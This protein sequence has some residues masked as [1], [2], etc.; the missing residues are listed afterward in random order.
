[1]QCCN[2]G[3]KAAISGVKNGYFYFICAHKFVAVAQ[4][5]VCVFHFHFCHHDC[6]SCRRRGC[7]V[8]ISL[9]GPWW[10]VYRRGR[11]FLHSEL[12]HSTLNGERVTRTTFDY[13]PCRKLSPELEKTNVKSLSAPVCEFITLI[14]VVMKCLI[15]IQGVNA[16]KPAPGL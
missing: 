13:S 9:C 1:M 2:I 4:N 10:Y 5:A 15:I 11:Y 6:T 12:L 3:N 7:V 16:S 8:F 14:C